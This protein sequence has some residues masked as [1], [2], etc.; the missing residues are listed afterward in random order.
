MEVT[1]DSKFNFERFLRDSKV[2]LK[3]PKISTIQVNLGKLCNLFCSHCHVGAGPNKTK[4]NMDFK[5]ASRVIELVKHSKHPLETLDITGGAP[6]LNPNFRRLIEQ[7][8]PYFDTV[9][10]RCNLS[11]LFEASQIGTAEFMAKHKVKIVASMPCYNPENVNAQRGDGSFDKSIAALKMLN[12]LG[13]GQKNSPLSLDLVYNPLGAT[14]PP[15]QEIL[16]PQYKQQLLK[17]FGISF[18]KLLCITNMPIKRFKFDLIKKG[19]YQGYLDCLVD[20]FNPQAAE[21]IMCKSLISVSWDGQ[22]YDCDFNQALNLK[23]SLNKP[24]IFD[25][26]DWSELQERSIKFASHCFGCTAGAGSS[27]SGKTVS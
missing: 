12:D 14:L 27:C 10:D 17:E 18:N 23:A 15:A 21:Q 22:L 24:N 19:D 20:H 3:R 6:E 7:C 13:Y 2:S 25:I 4:E 1:Y 9:I 16:E 26:Q 8:S 5:T 11:V